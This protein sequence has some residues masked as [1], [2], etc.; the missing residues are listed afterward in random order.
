MVLKENFTNKTTET[1]KL[2]KTAG[3][4]FNNSLSS[5]LKTI[6]ATVNDIA[7]KPTFMERLKKLLN[8]L[9]HIE[10]IS[11]AIETAPRLAEFMRTYD[12]TKDAKKAIL[13]AEEITVNFNRSGSFGKS[14][15]QVIPYFNA[16]VQGLNKLVTTLKDENGNRRAF[17][18]KVISSAVITTLLQVAFMHI[19]GDD[20]EE[21]Y[22]KLS[23]YKKNN[24]YNFYIGDGKF[25]S[26]SKPKEL[27]LMASFMERTV[28]IT[29]NEDADAK[30]EIEE[31]SAYAFDMLIPPLLDEAIVFGTIADIRANEDYK[32]TPIV[33]S[34]YESL[35]PEDQYN[36][37][38]SYLARILGDWF[39]YSPM[40]IDYIINSN[41]GVIGTLNQAFFSP[42]GDLTGGIKNK[43]YTDN[44][45][46]T[47]TFNK[48]YENAE[49]AAQTAASNPNDAEA[50]YRN[51][52]YNSVKS[53]VSALNQ[54]GKDLGL[55]R[56]Y[57]IY[58]QQYV[59][60]FEKN[61]QIDKRIVR[62]L[63][64]TGDK[65]ILYDKSFSATYSID[66]VKHTIPA[67]QYLDYIDEYYT[68]IEKAY[69]EILRYGY[70]D[71]RTVA[72][73][74]QAKSDVEKKLKKK[75]KTGE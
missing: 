39:G 48:F 50:I 9:N 35:L 43:F 41:L 38:T 24:F 31:Y 19:G 8:I 4:G 75:Y 67:E 23:S 69:D 22:A 54:Y 30:H 61:D 13:A 7:G 51:K 68:E 6:R 66:G 56:E 65:D 44:A 49:K 57:K 29:T 27:G 20:G 52:Q 34:Y 32:G 1:M 16:S 18:A 53:V 60:D 33:S 2:Y 46:S 74:K 17:I 55:E 73:L 15:D 59:A 12:K 28:E 71:E 10:N 40:K 72:M 36:E 58:A 3:G 45:Y 5:D 63:N 70:S 26:I 47:D 25:I 14:V 37:K 62:L 42:E 21:E 64:R 11:D